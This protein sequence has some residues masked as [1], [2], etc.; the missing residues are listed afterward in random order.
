MSS[1]SPEW[2]AGYE[3]PSGDS[4]KGNKDTQSHIARTLLGL[5][6]TQIALLEAD[7]ADWGRRTSQ[8]T[9]GSRL[10]A[11]SYDTDKADVSGFDDCIQVTDGGRE[12]C[13]VQVLHATYSQGGKR[14]L[15]QLQSDLSRL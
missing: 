10:C 1:V 2:L 6:R 9:A 13:W 4:I 3:A 14:A 8:H 12:K 15:L 11:F 7:E 5:T